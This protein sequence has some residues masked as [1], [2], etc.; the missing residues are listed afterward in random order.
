ER[1]GS[2]SAGRTRAVATIVSSSGPIRSRSSRRMR[3]RARVTPS[4]SPS[5][6]MKRASLRP[7]TSPSSGSPRC[8]PPRPRWS[9]GPWGG[10]PAF[11]V[12]S[13]AD[14][15]GLDPARELALVRL[16]ARPADQDPLDRRAVGR[17]GLLA[18]EPLTV[19]AVAEQRGQV[20][21]RGTPYRLGLPHDR[22]FA[23]VEPAH[24]APPPRWRIRR[25]CGHVVDELVDDR[26]R[27]EAVDEAAD[28]RDPAPQQPAG[29]PR[30]VRR[31]QLLGRPGEPGLTGGVDLDPE[32]GHEVASTAVADGADPP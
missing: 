25:P 7:G 22:G 5:S 16:A 32:V 11:G 8:P 12:T 3:A 30:P 1:G 31:G 15:A 29:P 19:A 28:A 17:Q 23:G 13:V 9:V 21:C 6:R 10:R 20:T 14:E 27:V 2:T 26:V 24:E 4:G 18:E